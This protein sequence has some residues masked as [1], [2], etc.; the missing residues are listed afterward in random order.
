VDA[1]PDG[2]ATPYVIRVEPGVYHEYVTVPPDKLHLTIMGTTGDPR[3]VV[4]T[5]SHYH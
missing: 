1:V 5:G 2:S 4:I 3:D